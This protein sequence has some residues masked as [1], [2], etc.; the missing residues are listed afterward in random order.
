MFGLSADNA[1][2]QD[3]RNRPETHIRIY[4]LNELVRTAQD[5]PLPSHLLPPSHLGEA[6]P[7]VKLP[8]EPGARSAS[9]G[10]EQQFSEIVRAVRDHVDPESW[11]VSGFVS[12]VGGRLIVQQTEENHRKIEDLLSQLGPAR[13]V[14][15][16]AWW[17][18]LD[19][20]QLRELLREGDPGHEGVQ[21]IDAAIF[22]DM[23][24][25]IVAYRGRTT[26]YDAQTAHVAA[27]VSKTVVTDVEPVVGTQV[28]TFDPTTRIVTFGAALQVRPRIL[29]S[30]DAAV[31][32]VHTVVSE[33]VNPD[34]LTDEQIGPDTVD[35]LW[36]HVHELRTTLRTPIAQPVLVGGLTTP[37]EEAEGTQL[38]LIVEVLTDHTD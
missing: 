17:V 1:D 12:S 37:S 21:P 4:D 3:A 33:E 15:V 26:G 2:A 14:T 28:S 6:A 35:R 19:A 34:A 27:G 8:L 32:D 18:R 16:R 5:Y 13:M 22:A 31:L 25:D 29:M 30:A 7:P 38:Y 23:D 11:D 9:K 10:Y 20:E 36:F 24:P